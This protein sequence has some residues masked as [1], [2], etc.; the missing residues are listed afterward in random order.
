MRVIASERCQ[1][2]LDHLVRFHEL[3]EQSGYAARFDVPSRVDRLGHFFWMIRRSSVTQSCFS[4]LTGNHTA[5]RDRCERPA[6]PD[7]ADGYRP[8]L[9][10]REAWSA[11]LSLDHAGVLDGLSGHL[12]RRIE[13]AELFV[14]G[15]ALVCVSRC[16]RGVLISSDA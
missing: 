13:G 11:R 8:V 6:A 12:R 9:V 15:R 16:L 7:T 1:C 14:E 5:R 2:L 4:M 10:C 3:L